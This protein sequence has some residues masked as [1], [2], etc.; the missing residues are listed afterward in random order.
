MQNP[1]PIIHFILGQ[2]GVG[3]TKMASDIARNSKGVMVNCDSRQVYKGLDI[4]TGKIDNPKDVE[5]LCTDIVTPKDIFSAYDY[6][7]TAIDVIEKLVSE[8]KT[9]IVVGGTGMYAYLLKNIDPKQKMSFKKQDSNMNDVTLEK[10][11]DEIQLKYPFIWEKL[12]PSDR[13]NKRRLTNAI[14]RMIAGSAGSIDIKSQNTLA[15]RYTL[16]EKIF[17]HKDPGSL[18][19]RIRN[20]VFE[21]IQNGAIGECEKLLR[22]GYVLADPGLNSIGYRSVFKFLNREIS[23]SQM[24]EEWFLKERQY[25]KRQKTYLLKYFPN[26]ETIY[27]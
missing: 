8:N 17:L 13:Q 20:R 11:Q 9:P 6:S 12:N 7:I 3:K 15:N 26:A 4:I 21:R 14:E 24:L 16:V 1:K 10:L 25:A 5:V 23:E 27:I 18:E 2:T 19:T 22:D